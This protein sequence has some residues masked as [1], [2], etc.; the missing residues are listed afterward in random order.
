V[1]ELTLS[2]S[3]V[4][5][6][7]DHLASCLPEEGCGLLAGRAARVSEVIPVPNAA[8][9]A[10]RFLMEPRAQLLA[11]E[12]IEQEGLELLGIFHSHPAG[13]DGPSETDMREAA[14]PAVQVIWSKSSGEWRARGYWLEETGPSEVQL[15]IAGD[16]ASP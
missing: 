14:Y 12:R 8:R 15:R 11:L 4:Q 5:Q 3:Q 9:S 10:T 7:Q 2:L 16:P 13:P 1:K 6:M